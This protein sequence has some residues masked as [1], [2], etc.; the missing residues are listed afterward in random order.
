MQVLLLGFVSGQRS[1]TLL[2]V[3][4][5]SELAYNWLTGEIGSTVPRKL[6][7]EPERAC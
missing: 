7:D 1:S 6:E 4:P 2:L 3:D 5:Y